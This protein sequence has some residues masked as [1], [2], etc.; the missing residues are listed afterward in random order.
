MLVKGPSLKKRPHW[1][2]GR[3]LELIY[4]DDNNVRSVRLKRGDGVIQHH[5]I[6]HLY[7]MELSLTHHF[8]TNDSS[9]HTQENEVVADGD[10]DSPAENIVTQAIEPVIDQDLNNDAGMLDQIMVPDVE[11]ELIVDHSDSSN[12]ANQISP[13]VISQVAEDTVHPSGRPKR[14][15][16]KNSRPLDEQFLY[17]D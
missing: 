15:I 5:S 6:S 14:R 13:I 12:G 17:Y 1:I 11:P 7:P 3:V 4:G 8:V 10:N 16:V 9:S 2:L